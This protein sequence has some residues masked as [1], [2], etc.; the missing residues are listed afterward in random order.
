VVD[1]TSAATTAR[2]RFRTWAARFAALGAL[3]GAIIWWWPRPA[4]PVSTGTTTGD[5]ALRLLDGR[6]RQHLQ[7]LRRPREDTPAPGTVRASGRV[8]DGERAPVPFVEV[9]FA[10]PDGET[11]TIADATGHYDLALAPGT[12]RAYARGDGILS[13]GEPRDGAEPG[14]HAAWEIG[15][16]DVE[17]AIEVAVLHDTDDIDLEVVAS[18]VIEG[19]VVDGAGAAVAGALVSLRGPSRSVIGADVAETDAAGRFRLEAPVGDTWLGASHAD[20][21]GV[22]WATATELAVERGEVVHT[23]LVLVA[24]CIVRGR[25]V[26]ADGTPVGEGTVGLEDTFVDGAVPIGADGSF[27][28]M[29][30]DPDDV[31]LRAVP[32]RFA[33]SRPQRLAC[34]D[35]ARF[36]GVVLEIDDAAPDLEGT[37]VAADGSPAAGARLRFEPKDDGLEWQN[38]RADREGRWALYGVAPGRY[39]VTASIDGAGAIAEAVTAPRRGVR[40]RLG[41]A[42]V[43]V[44]S[45]AG[46]DGGAV[47]L[48]LGPCRDDLMP[49]GPALAR[50]WIPVR[51][52]RYRLDGV[53]ACDRLAVFRAAGHIEEHWISVAAGAVVTLDVDLAPRRRKVVT[54]VVRRKYG[55]GVAGATGTVTAVHVDGQPTTPFT[56]GTDGSFRVEASVGDLVRAEIDDTFFTAGSIT[57]SDAPG[58]EERVDIELFTRYPMT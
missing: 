4:P 27:R 37:I 23:E 49:E 33:P 20:F 46:V 1:R 34:R 19:R 2:T 58:D 32:L 55:T 15:S 50:R 53:P 16:P 5:A 28:W 54:G 52:G 35:G 18:G 44:G 42:G 45:A 38:T 17:L 24:G 43:L 29:T 25:V 48:E 7:R 51:D 57:V 21:A 11:S 8:V 22:D 56:V 14:P 47:S 31:V 36:D 26:G 10:G 9:V 41:G 12:Y 13:V 3:I 30:T 6:W 39:Q 40:L